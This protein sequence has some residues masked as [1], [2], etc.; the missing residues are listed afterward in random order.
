MANRNE[1]EGN[2]TATRAYDKHARDFVATGQ[3]AE[4]AREAA[5]A[6]DGPEGRDLERAEARG[7]AHAREEDRLLRPSASKDAGRH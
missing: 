7:K 4:K 1:G 2:R 3:V 6:V 5:D